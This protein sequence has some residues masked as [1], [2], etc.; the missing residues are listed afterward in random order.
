MKNRKLI[1]IIILILIT[2]FGIYFSL[3]PGPVNNQP[4]TEN[5]AEK[6]QQQLEE[7]FFT[8]YDSDESHRL[9]L[10]TEDLKNYSQQKRMEL[11]PVHVEVYND[12]TGE[13][14]YIMDGES[15]VYYT[16]DKI[17]NIQGPVEFD[18]NR[19]TIYCMEIVYDL[20]EDNLKGKKDVEI[21]GPNFVG[22]GHRFQ[23]DL[24][25][26]DLQLFRGENKKAVINFEESKNEK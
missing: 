11:E 16:D 20:K 26:E 21:H 5:G 7:V 17:L 15:G 24:N 4:E 2:A 6:P 9:E 14:L 22:E 23:S 8:V 3:R 12:D 1:L 25:I 10:Q 19:Y 13:L 18:R